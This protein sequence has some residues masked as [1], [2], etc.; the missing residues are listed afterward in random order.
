MQRVKR[1]PLVLPVF[2]SGKWYDDFAVTGASESG[3]GL[4]GA[5][6][7]IPEGIRLRATTGTSGG[8]TLPNWYKK[9]N[10]E[11]ETIMRLIAGST[12]TVNFRMLNG[13]NRLYFELTPSNTLQLYKVVTGV[14][15]QLGSSITTTSTKFQKINAR[16]CGLQIEI[17]LNGIKVISVNDSANIT[18]KLFQLTTYDSGVGVAQTEFQ[19]FAIKPI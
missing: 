1:R 13:D 14:F 15:T 12:C 7:K 16:V 11:L 6:D 19:Y 2:K 10:F 9:N 8:I 5:K 3:Y 17:F 18:N 4:V